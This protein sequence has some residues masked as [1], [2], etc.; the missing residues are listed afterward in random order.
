MIGVLQLINAQD[1]NGRAVPFGSYEQLVA[2]SLSCKPRSHSTRIR[3]LIASG[4]S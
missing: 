2:E 4:S 3:F 1:E